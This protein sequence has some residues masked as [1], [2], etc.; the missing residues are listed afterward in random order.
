[1]EPKRPRHIK[2]GYVN[3]KDLP[4]GSN[5]YCLCRQCEVEVKPPRKTFCSQVCVDKWMIRTGSGLERAIKKRDHG[6]CAFCK[7]DCER[8]SKQLR[9]LTREFWKQYHD[10][11]TTRGRGRRAEEA[12]KAHVAAFKAEHGIPEHRKRRL[13]DID[14]IVPV[15]EGGGDCDL[16]NLRVLCI[17][18]H[19]QVTAELAA[20]RAA[21]RRI[22]K[23]TSPLDAA[24]SS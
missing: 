3:P 12:L 24:K 22:A 14:H 20:K 10:P 5:G 13:W 7:L 15:V 11:D 16:T 18:C 21:A 9:R 2:G 1:M 6:I 8:L 17:K 4:K 23:A 19:K